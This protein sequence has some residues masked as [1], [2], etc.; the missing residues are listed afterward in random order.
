[1]LTMPLGVTSILALLGAAL[2]AGWLL[3]DAD[4]SAG[5]PAP[6]NLAGSDGPRRASG[7]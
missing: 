6:R 4:V 5:R 1:M 7:H 3:E 2:V